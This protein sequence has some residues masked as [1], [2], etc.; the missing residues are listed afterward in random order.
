MDIV[1]SQ[2]HMFHC[3]DIEQ[4]LAAMD[5]LG[6]SGAVVDEFWHGATGAPEPCHRLS[7]GDYRPYAPG[8]ERASALHPRRFCHLLRVRQQDP[9]AAT[10]IRLARAH[11]G[12]KALR[13]D[14]S[15]KDDVRLFADGA[16]DDIFAAAA[17]TG[18]PVFVLTYDRPALIER[19]LTA[20]PSVPMILD[21]CGFMADARDYEIVLRL[22]RYPN[23]FLKWCHARMIF[24]RGEWPYHHLAA[25]LRRAI[26]A[27]GAE[28]I[29]WASDSSMV[30]T[31]ESWAEMLFYLRDSG[32]GLSA[33][34]R[35]WILGRATRTV[36]NWPAV[37]A[38]NPRAAEFA[39]IEEE[40]RR[41]P[42]G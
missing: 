20:F 4:S 32:C 33:E 42:R 39:A 9:D 23:A 6:I 14:A 3:M 8:A 41:G 12:L 34:E 30:T 15:T 2:H 35:E 7:G 18:L 11:P 25:P 22:A 1:D 24:G 36:L 40:Y 21:H 5:A 29:L 10:M 38:D 31:G 27:F 37:A 28:R 16:Y 13:C 26:D 17:D 19:Y